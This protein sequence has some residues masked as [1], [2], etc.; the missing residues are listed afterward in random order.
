MYE[1]LVGALERLLEEG[2]RRGDAVVR[3]WAALGLLDALDLGLA[4]G[5]TVSDDAEQR[6]DEVRAIVEEID[7][8][9]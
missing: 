2:Q 4:T 1:R 5:M 9:P 7:R 8:S 3:E 6:R